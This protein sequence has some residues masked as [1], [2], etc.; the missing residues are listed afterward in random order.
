MLVVAAA[1]VLGAAPARDPLLYV[2]NQDPA[3]ASVI[4]ARTHTLL[5]T[6]DLQQLGFSAKAK[7]HHTAVEPDG[8]Y[9]YV[10]LIGDGWVVKLDRRNRVVAKAAFQTPGMLA[11]DRH[12]D[13]LYV[14]RSMTASNPPS[15][16]GI[17]R[18]KTM[19][20][21]E[22]DVLIPHPHAIALDPGGAWV[23]VG[24][25]AANN[26][27]T[28]NA[29]T[30]QVSLSDVPGDTMAQMLVQLAI[31]PDGTRLVATTQMTDKLVVFDATTPTALRALTT[32]AVGAWPWDPLFTPDGK[33]VWFG[34]QRANSVTVV[35]ATTWQIAS[36]ISGNGIAEPHG[37]AVTPDG[38]TVF[39][40]NHNLQGE[41]T[42]THPAGPRGTG[43]VVVIDRA[44]RKIQDV[45]ETDR[46]AAGMSLGE[47]SSP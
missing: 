21:E 43:T 23:Y 19:A 11:L 28:V 29:R 22:L 7:P 42:P 31:S 26:L 18:R 12:S 46:Y 8:S 5:Q 47:G 17:I 39:V 15:R 9:W 24:S 1:G 13:L 36:V 10:T 25:M 32:L 14:T 16:I 41:Y 2:A 6:I 4:D 20:I 44:Q 35:D 3:T 38:R 27:A 30:E 34:N 33:E 37:I 40:S 45:I